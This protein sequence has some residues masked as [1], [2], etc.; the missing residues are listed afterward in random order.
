M[1]AYPIIKEK[2]PAN[3]HYKRCGENVRSK[4]SYNLNFCK[5]HFVFISEKTTQKGQHF[6]ENFEM[7]HFCQDVN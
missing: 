3:P 5:T 2:E 6:C 7:E 1:E 4:I